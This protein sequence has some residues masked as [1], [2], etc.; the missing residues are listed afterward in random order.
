MSTQ[1]SCCNSSPSQ[2]APLLSL[3][4]PNGPFRLLLFL[5]LIATFTCSSRTAASFNASSL[6]AVERKKLLCFNATFNSS[7]S[8]FDELLHLLRLLLLFFFFFFGLSLSSCFFLFFSTA[9]SLCSPAAQGKVNG[10][11]VEH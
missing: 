6:T 2:L 7:H 9:S 11:S 8:Y 4:L 1:A 5:H 10:R 3:F